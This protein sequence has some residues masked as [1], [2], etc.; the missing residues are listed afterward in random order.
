MPD[1]AFETLSGAKETSTATN[2]VS[3]GANEASVAAFEM[4]DATNKTSDEA[5]EVSVVAESQK[6][7][8]KLDF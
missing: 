8:K 4:S 2:G 1:G 3:D 5:F 6:S 7:G